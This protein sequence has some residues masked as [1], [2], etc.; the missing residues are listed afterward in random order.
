MEDK[1][2][3]LADS[4]N[5]LLVLTQ[6]QV[7]RMDLR[8]ESDD[9]QK[10]YDKDRVVII[11]QRLLE[12]LDA[13]SDDC[14]EVF[15]V[16]QE[17]WALILAKPF[18]RRAK[19]DDADDDKHSERIDDV[20]AD[21]KVKKAVTKK[22]KHLEPFDYLQAVFKILPTLSQSKSLP[23]CTQSAGID[24][25]TATF[26]FTPS[27]APA[28]VH[29]LRVVV[30]TIAPI[31]PA[32][33]PRAEISIDL[34]SQTD[35]TTACLSLLASYTEFNLLSFVG[36]C[37]EQNGTLE[38]C[39]P[40]LLVKLLQLS[41]RAQKA[42]QDANCSSQKKAFALRS[43]S[44]ASSVDV[45]TVGASSE[46]SG[47]VSKTDEVGL[48][49]LE[50]L[51]C[52]PRQKVVSSKVKL[53]DDDEAKTDEQ[54]AEEAA[55][56][57]IDEENDRIHNSLLELCHSRLI[58]L[59]AE[60]GGAVSVLPDFVSLAVTQLPS[61]RYSSGGINARQLSEQ[62]LA[63]LSKLNSCIVKLARTH[64]AYCMNA[65][66]SF[67]SSQIATALSHG[68]VQKPVEEKNPKENF[69]VSREMR[70]EILVYDLFLTKI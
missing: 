13:S 44:Y 29:L 36:I 48:K 41:F 57:A 37:W 61:E 7:G 56:K 14:M 55:T 31:C 22:M 51:C 46:K 59:Y 19:N 15:Q 47:Q 5:F 68:T 27:T 6:A 58:S 69:R 52:M 49:L 62:R 39:T 38:K 67:F 45:N 64:N 16:A 34:S 50:A 53:N 20:F 11:L 18:V 54:K 10:L 66:I 17:L 70:D 8:L 24:V 4:L 2:S 65:A 60:F 42:I 63:T 1:T 32:M 26:T 33:V 9:H 3:N 23:I 30:N 35:Y 21:K 43:V 12:R 40:D 28:Q 25:P